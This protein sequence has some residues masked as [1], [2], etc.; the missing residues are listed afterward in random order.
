MP[1]ISQTIKDNNIMKYR[2]FFLLIVMGLAACG[3]ET[4]PTQESVPAE[5]Q[6][7]QPGALPNIT[8]AN[9]DGALDVIIPA[10]QDAITVEYGM[11]I[12]NHGKA[13]EGEEFSN[14]AIL[15]PD[16]K[17]FNGGNVLQLGTE[18]SVFLS[19]S[20]VFD[21]PGE[22]VLQFAADG[23]NDIDE[24]NEDDNLLSLSVSVVKE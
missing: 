14:M 16:G 11:V 6:Q 12:T 10:R 1:G 23:N 3:G 15:L 5:A 18:Q 7:L 2:L 13:I 8:I 21:S 22:F 9:V 17:Q 4:V 20:V 24:S 19:V